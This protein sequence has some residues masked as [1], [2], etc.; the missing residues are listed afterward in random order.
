MRLV[1]SESRSL[2][3]A[4]GLAM[5][6]GSYSGMRIERPVPCT[7]CPAGTSPHNLTRTI[8][9]VS[10]DNGFRVEEDLC[11]ARYHE[12]IKELLERDDVFADLPDTVLERFAGLKL[13]QLR[14]RIAQLEADAVAEDRLAKLRHVLNG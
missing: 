7:E 2:F 11:D 9:Y 12:R 4:R 10:F 8:R 5:I 13:A 6:R 3:T 14:E 1:Q